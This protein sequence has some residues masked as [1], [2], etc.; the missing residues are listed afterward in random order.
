MLA[1]PGG[2]NKAAFWSENYLESDGSD[3]NQK[4]ITQKIKTP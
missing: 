3:Q 2:N 1:L 4:E